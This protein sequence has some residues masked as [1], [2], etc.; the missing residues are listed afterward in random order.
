MFTCPFSDDH[1]GS[2][3]TT[4]LPMLMVDAQ[5]KPGDALDDVEG[6]TRRLAREFETGREDARQ[7]QAL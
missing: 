1:L 4:A 6:A 2:S 3:S 7:S 5:G